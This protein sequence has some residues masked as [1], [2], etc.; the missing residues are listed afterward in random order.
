M[1]KNHFKAVHGP[2]IMLLSFVAML[3][4]Q[5]VMA[6]ALIGTG[7]TEGE[8]YEILNCVGMILFQLVYVAVYLLYTQKNKIFSTFSPKNKISLLGIA[9]SVAVTLVCFFGFIGLAYYFEYLLGNVGY[10][11][12]T[13]DVTTPIGIALLV[14]ATVVAAPIGEETIFRSAL[15]SGLV[16]NRKDD[17]GVCLISGVCFALMHI[18]PS[19]TVYQLCLGAASAYVMLKGRSVIY[20]MVMHA[21]SNALALIVSFTSL[22]VG[23]E[24]FYAQTGESVWITLLTCV[25]LPVV[26][27]TLVWLIG[28]CFKRYETKRLPAKYKGEPKIIWID[29]ITKEPIFEGEDAPVITEQNRTF[30]R[31]FNPYT[32]KP[33]MVDRIELQNALRE[34]YYQNNNEKSGLFGKNT[35]KIV[36][37]IYFVIT[38]FMWLLTFI[39]GFN[40]V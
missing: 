31:G 11:G 5:L 38:I 28:R 14:V 33:V 25:V 18:N 21:L 19:Q 26:A 20:A 16:K 15:C 8:L 37:C 13:L 6:F 7:A 3:V 9:V 1:K 23:V 24:A 36:F 35:Y 10:V 34:E 17:L 32:G 2:I 4:M 29:E 39:S 40:V 12:A 30:Q 22:G 27:V